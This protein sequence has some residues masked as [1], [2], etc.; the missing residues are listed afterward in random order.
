MCGMCNSEVWD[1]TGAESRSHL[2]VKELGV[3]RCILEQMGIL[4]LVFPMGERR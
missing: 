2:K 4:A 1:K 3:R